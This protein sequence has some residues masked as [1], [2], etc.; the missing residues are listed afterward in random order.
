M[1]KIFI[2]LLILLFASTPCF[3]R[4]VTA[5]RDQI[6]A[7]QD[8]F[9][10]EEVE[11]AGHI[12]YVDSGQSHSGNGK[13]WNGAFITLQEAIGFCE[14]DRGDTIYVAPGHA[15]DIISD[16]LIDLNVRG[17]SVKGMGN[18]NNRPTFTVST[19]VDADMH[20]TADDCTISNLIFMNGINNLATMLTVTANDVT[21]SECYFTDGSATDGLGAI[22]V[23]SADGTANRLTIEDCGFYQPGD[24]Y[25]DH[26]IEILFDMVGTRILRNIFYGDY[27]EGAIRIPTAAD[28]C[29]NMLF[30]ENIITNKQATGKGIYIDGTSA[31][32]TLRSNSIFTDDPDNSY[33]F[34]STILQESAKLEKGALKDGTGVYPASVADDSLWAK[35]LSKSAT[36]SA[37]SYSNLTDSFE[38]ISDTLADSNTGIDALLVHA[39]D[40]N[41][42][43]EARDVFLTDMNTADE[44]RD[45]QLTDMN[46]ADEA[47]D[48][49]LTDMNTTIESMETTDTARDVQLTDMNTTIESMETADTARDVWLTDMNTADEAR[50]VHLVDVNTTLELVETTV[51][52]FTA[53]QDAN[54]QQIETHVVDVNTWLVAWTGR[55]D[56]NI[57]QIEA[58]TATQDTNIATIIT[59]TGI[60]D[61]N[62]QDIETISDATS[63]WMGVQD[64]NIQQIETISD[65]TSTWMGVQDTN[66]A[67]LITWTGVQ[68]ANIQ[69][70]ETIADAT[71]TWM[72][73]QDANIAAIIVDF[74][75]SGTQ[76]CIVADVNVQDLVNNTQ[77]ATSDITTAASGDLYLEN[78]VVQTDSANTSASAWAVFEISTDNTHGA[79]G[80][81]SPIV[82]EAKATF[83]GSVTLAEADF[84]TEQFPLLIESGTT[85]YCHGSSAAGDVDGVF[86]IMMCFRRIDDAASLTALDIGTIP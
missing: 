46:T 55:Q 52:T 54:I 60:Q 17:V 43:N 31:T 16:G 56:A 7:L 21:I 77:G 23:G 66:I 75:N 78:I 13:T 29:I 36:P 20:I 45:V 61:A 4:K 74:T 6:D 22:A 38:A 63:T 40:M 62:I 11:Q 25:N 35:I 49:Y 67:A 51:N 3:A 14:D 72:G 39:V 86:R 68:D 30:E 28:A 80:P 71:S 37:S 58:W 33:S 18:G 44:A 65:A 19:A 24:T 53:A 9:K 82:T 26:A 64:A 10:G 69:Q 41:T 79:T 57:G 27:D 5:L 84:D 1:K 12:W 47:R 32:I 48:V 8:L 50:D 85:I 73:T 15:Y 42:A 83:T 81:D 34:D 2:L 70:I 76:F 59:W